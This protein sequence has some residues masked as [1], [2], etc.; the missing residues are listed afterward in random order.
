[1]KRIL[2]VDDEP[3][4]LSGLKASLRKHRRQWNM[5][6]ASGGTE[7]LG[8]L[9]KEPFDVVVSDMRMPGI[10]GAEL[11]GRVKASY[12]QVIR[13][14]L[15]G[16]TELDATM[17]TVP[18]AHQFL[19]K[20]CEPSIL[21]R[22]V[23]RAFGLETLLGDPKLRE[24]VGGLDRLPPIPKTYQAVTECLSSPASNAHAL[25]VIIE[26]DPAICAKLLQLVNSAFFAS[27]MRITD[28]QTATTR[29][30]FELIKELVLAIEVFGNAEQLPQVPYLSIPML[31]KRSM[32]SAQIARSLLTGQRA[33]DAFI[34]GMLHEIGLLVLASTQPDKLEAALTLADTDGLPI[35]QAEERLLGVNHGE[36]GG[37]LL[38]LWGLPIPI[39]ETIAL[40][41]A[42]VRF[43]SESRDVLSA[44]RIGA[45]IAAATLDPCCEL[46]PSHEVLRVLGA[47][48][49][50]EQ[51]QRLARQELKR[52]EELKL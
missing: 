28:V 9:E 52:I 17:R 26:Q 31:Q 38:G 46:D 42:T 21:E 12:P 14:V 51:L 22:V 39:V 24:A 25:A 32:L 3:E 20:P 45:A 7:A 49:E 44:V 35:D 2:F 43:P 18:V 34:A 33:K 30:G 50:V 1:M 40:R 23:E 19:T 47:S 11:L 48:T 8:I 6:F 4:I 36:V 10:D 27:A 13:I 37:Y 15:S 41:T 16:H 5:M 29:L